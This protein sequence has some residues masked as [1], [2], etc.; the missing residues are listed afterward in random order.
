[1]GRTCVCGADSLRIDAKKRTLTTQDGTEVAEGDPISIDGTTGEVFAGEVPVVDSLVVRYFEGDDDEPGDELVAAVAR[2]MEHADRARRLA[3]R[4]NADT[5]DDAARA[6]R[7]GAQGIGLCRTEHMFLGER[8]ALVEAL[9]L[10]ESE[11]EQEKALSELLPMQRDDFVG[12]LEAMDGLPVTIRLIDPP[13]HEFLPDY[14][15]LCVEVALDEERGE[16]DEKRQT[17]LEAVKR[18]HEENPMLGLRGVRLGIVIPGLFAMQARAILEAAALR[19]KAGGDPHPEIM[20]PLV[21]TVQEL[22]LVRA[23]IEQVVESIE[24]DTGIRPDYKIGTMIELPRAVMAA[25][26]IAGAAEFFSFGTN[27]LTQMT[28]GFSR[29]DVEAS[30]FGAYLEKG[31]FGVSPFESLD[32][33]GVGGLVRYAARKGREA[34][35]DLH[36]G[37]CGEHGGDPDSIHFFDDAGLDYVSCSP[38]RVPVARL[39]AGRSSAEDRSA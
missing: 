29:D 19:K 31:I 15:D 2:V 35:P 37:V 24:S 14:T 20:I 38:F 39:E 5:P 28:W 18:L 11:D 25:G 16:V 36:L 4:A 30:F 13:L 33:E 12:I 26:E 21:A 17:L 23:D 9:I 34:R 10:A 1:M 6:R 32:T 8:K 7:F 27:D 3:V 22:E